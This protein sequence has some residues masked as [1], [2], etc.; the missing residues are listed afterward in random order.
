MK[1]SEIQTDAVSVGK[2]TEHII[3]VIES[4]YPSQRAAILANLRNSIGKSLTE[5]GMVWPLIFENL[6]Q[7]FLSRNGNET[8]EEKA[9]FNALQLY[10]MC[11][12]G[13]SEKV[14]SDSHYKG[15]VGKSLSGIRDANDS[16]AL[17]RRFN[18]LITSDTYSELTYHLRQIIKIAKSK[19]NI[20]INFPKLADDLFWFQRGSGKKVC[21]RWAQ[22]Y[23]SKSKTAIQ[24]TSEEEN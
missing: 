13:A 8:P 11:M 5:A 2:V 7:E 18:A 24:S 6:P 15:S 12:Q 3:R 19:G 20:T 22:D 9:V 10:S 14:T 1:L 4:Q 23:Y 17:D 16:Q 21:L